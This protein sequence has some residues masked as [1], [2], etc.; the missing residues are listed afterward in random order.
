MHVTRGHAQ[1]RFVALGLRGEQLD[2]RIGKL[3]PRSS[4]RADT[5]LRARII[6]GEDLAIGM[7]FL[8]HDLSA[9]LAKADSMSRAAAVKQ[10]ARAFV[11]HI[12]E[13]A[14]EAVPSDVV[15]DGGA[16]VQR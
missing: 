6:K 3:L 1:Q 15:A 7:A 2:I 12:V 8:A 5:E 11:A 13:I 14:L 10:D 4:L 9:D 16:K